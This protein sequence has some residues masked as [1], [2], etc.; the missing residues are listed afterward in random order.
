MNRVPVDAVC[1][2][3]HESDV[4]YSSLKSRIAEFKGQWLNSNMPSF[5]VPLPHHWVVELE[6]GRKVGFL[7]LN[8]GGGSFASTYRKDAFGGHA[9]GITPILESVEDV[10]ARCRKEHPDLDCILP[11]T[12]QVGP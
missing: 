9:K 6:G 12:H 1:F 11:L 2:G 7:G 10:V 5:E 8:I 3:N 4:P